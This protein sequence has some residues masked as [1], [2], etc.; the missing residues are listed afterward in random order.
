MEKK[1]Y[2]NKVLIVLGVI[3]VI[4]VGIFIYQ[5][6][7]GMNSNSRVT[8]NSKDNNANSSISK[9]ENDN[10]SN[11]NETEIT[12]QDKITI[13]NFCEFNILSTSFSKN[14]DL[15]RSLTGGGAYAEKIWGR[16]NALMEWKNA[17]GV[18]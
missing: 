10:S 9:V 4:V 14:I 5:N 13:D 6:K 7:K 12:L 11:K 18:Y 2:K 8:V 16:R 1:N 17:G 3:I 15:W